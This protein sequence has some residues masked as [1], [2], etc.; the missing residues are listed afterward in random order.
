MRH[1]M[2]MCVLQR[3]DVWSWET[4]PRHRLRHRL[5]RGWVKPRL[6]HRCRNGCRGENHRA[7]RQGRRNLISRAEMAAAECS[8]CVVSVLWVEK[9]R[10]NGSKTMFHLEIEMKQ[11]L[12]EN[13]LWARQAV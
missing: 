7:Q 13:H 1:P 4:G 9:G 10:G 12:L 5:Q 6:L 3:R 2:W 11:P 8:L